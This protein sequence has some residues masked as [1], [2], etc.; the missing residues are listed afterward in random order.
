MILVLVQFSVAILAAR[1][2]DRI[3]RTTEGPERRKL[4]RTLWIT[5]AGFG[6]ILGLLGGMMAVGS[7]ESMATSQ[8]V[9]RAGSTDDPVKVLE[10][11]ETLSGS[12]RAR[13]T[14]DLFLGIVL[15]GAGVL[16]I[17]TRIKGLL[18]RSAVLVGILGLALIDLWRVNVQPAT[19]RPR[20]QGTVAATP[21]VEFLQ[22]DPEPFRF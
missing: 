17:W 4:A 14:K 18:P 8:L 20:N 21:V 13:A 5:A 11:A 15:L 10:A 12:I 7:M 9:Q 6:V 2:L 3:L 1:G 16:L 22:Q 19:Y